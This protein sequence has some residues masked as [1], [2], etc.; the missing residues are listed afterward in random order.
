MP[1]NSQNE[2]ESKPKTS[3]SSKGSTSSG[4]DSDREVL[5]NGLAAH[6]AA[7]ERFVFLATPL[8]VVVLIV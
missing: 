5:Q 1:A 3:I 2:P 7:R 4:L 8:I 6:D